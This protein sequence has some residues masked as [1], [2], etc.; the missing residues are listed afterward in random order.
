MNIALRS[1][2]AT[3]ALVAMT[4]VASA[5]GGLWGYHKEEDAFEGDQHIAM[6]TDFSEVAGFRCKDADDLVLMYVTMQKP[7]DDLTEGFK[8]TNNQL[9]LIV[10]NNEKMEFQAEVDET[11]QG[12]KYRFISLGGDV[13]KAVRMAVA[14][15]K[16]FAIA[17]A[18]NGHI[19]SSRTFGM[20]GSTKSLNKLVQGCKL[21][22][23]EKRGPV[24]PELETP[25]TAPHK[26]IAPKPEASADPLPDPLPEGFVNLTDANFIDKILTAK[27]GDKFRQDF[28]ATDLALCGNDKAY[29]R[30]K[31]A[32]KIKNELKRMAAMRQILDSGDCA[33]IKWGGLY[34]VT[35]AMPDMVTLVEIS[36]E[37]TN[38]D[39]SYVF[40]RGEP[41]DVT[42]GQS[43]N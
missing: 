39:K 4:A 26:T 9:F 23:P 22:K 43:E 30:K 16:R 17:A 1:A 6:V 36:A 14:A 20:A 3:G 35:A 40:H 31:A 33:Q 29:E 37:G 27:A 41:F 19:A 28:T 24:P 32:F 5:G 2:M 25:E 15:K 21:D 7:S 11:P 13:E 10:D 42:A 12:D 18:I 8:T 38:A 34:T